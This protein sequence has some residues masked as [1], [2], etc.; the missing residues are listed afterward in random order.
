MDDIPI[1]IKTATDSAQIER[2]SMFSL[3]LSHGGIL[4]TT[5]ILKSLN[6]ARKTVLRTMAEFKAI[7]LVDVEDFHEPEQNNVSKR[8]VLNP[9]LSWLLTDSV[10]TKI[11]PHTTYFS[12]GGGSGPSEGE[13]EKMEDIAS[14]FWSIFGRLENGNGGTN[15]VIHNE[16]YEALLS[17]GK[18]YQG[19][20]TQIIEDMVKAGRLELVSFHL[21]R[22][23]LQNH[24]KKEVV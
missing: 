11:F 19:D 7:G 5:Q 3:L 16:L 10:I 13:G 20:A 1:V 6:V 8:M 21:Y 9:S 18:F 23:I 24:E 2:V 17:S 14:V 4:T 22:K 12:K 15:T